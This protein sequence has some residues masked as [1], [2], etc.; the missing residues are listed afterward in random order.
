MH[1]TSLLE[2]FKKTVLFV[3]DT[4]YPALD[5]EKYFTPKE[6]QDSIELMDQECT[7]LLN[8]I[9]RLDLTRKMQDKRLTNV[10]HLV[11]LLIPKARPPVDI[12]VPQGFS[13]VNIQDSKRMH[14][15]TEAAVRDSAGSYSTY[16]PPDPFLTEPLP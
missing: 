10:M 15:L 1:Y 14:K 7:N 5:N 4:H 9:E 2:D 3:K 12:D 16:S 8:Q 11:R 13:T 6:R